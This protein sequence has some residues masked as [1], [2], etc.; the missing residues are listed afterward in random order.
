[1]AHAYYDVRL[2]KKIDDPICSDFDNQANVCFGVNCVSD[3]CEKA[4]VGIRRFREFM[5]STVGLCVI[6]V[7][8]FLMY[9]E[10]KICAYA[11][12]I[13]Y[14]YGYLCLF[15]KIESNGSA[16]GISFK[17][18]VL[19]VYTMLFNWWALEMDFNTVKAILPCILV[20]LMKWRHGKTI[21]HENDSLTLHL[22][23]PGLIFGGVMQYYTEDLEIAVWASRLY[24]NVIS[25][26]YQSHMMRRFA[27]TNNGSVENLSGQYVMAIVA[28]R[29]LTCYEAIR[30]DEDYDFEMIYIV[31]ALSQ[32]ALTADF[33]YYWFKAWQNGM[34]IQLPS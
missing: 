12:M 32:M 3:P 20:W 19:Q 17:M 27:N 16:K 23:W 10:Q 15:L 7:T 2:S 5:Q 6:I 22:L 28:Y 24:T 33:A 18:A 8:T 21:D 9:P 26:L 30:F 11:E 25:T 4:S 13:F 14:C 29:S 31:C 1:M 34:P